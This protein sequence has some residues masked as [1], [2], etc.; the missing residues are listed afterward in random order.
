MPEEG[1]SM[2]EE[3]EWFVG[4]DWASQSHQVCLVDAHGR[5]VGERAVPHGGAGIE[6]LCD[7][8]IARTGAA[9]EAIAVAIEMPQGPVVEALL[10][11]GFRVHAI[12]PKQLDRFRDRFTVAG[13]KDDRR[14]AHVLADSLRTDRHAFRRLSVDHPVIVELRDWSRMADDL[15]Q[16]RNRLA[17]RMRE[18]LWR[19]YPQMLEVA[20]DF[21]TDWFLDL[22]SQ[23]PTPAKAARLRE[24]TIERF[25]NAHRIRRWQAPE[26]LRILKQKPLSVAPG[27]VEA[28]T[29][30][31]RTLTARIRLVNHQ[32]KAA[33]RKLDELC[34]QLI[35]PEENTPGQG[36][37]QRDVVIL[38]SMPGLGRIILAVLLA[39]AWQPLRR[40]DYHALRC[41][42]GVAP[43]TRR[44]GKTCVVVRRYACNK[45]LQNALYHWARVAVQ[46]DEISRNRYAALRRRGHSHARALRTVADRLLSVACTL[47]GQQ[48]LFDHDYE[49]RGAAAA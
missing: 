17:N 7:W 30:H 31:I 40:R 4:I 10:E 44:S 18:Q 48:I 12:N 32:L 46:H 26:V 23:A 36:C 11:R 14:D 27:V 49:A 3:V 2:A 6:E 39:E 13:A 5:C 21:A 9:P 16:E 25:L 38:R 29:A 37:E 35:P 8:L 1:L 45:R 15:Q 42:S 24:T 33:H 43:V 28:A 19:Y 47:L 20:D 34:D 22:W 41:L